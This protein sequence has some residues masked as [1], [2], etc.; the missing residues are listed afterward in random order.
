MKKI[1]FLLV[2]AG[3]L[4]GAY[5]ASLSPTEVEWAKFIPVLFIG[6]VGVVLIKI[7][8]KQHATSEETLTSNRAD[9]ENSLNRI[10]AGLEQLEAE[11]ETIAVDKLRDEIDK[12]LRED[13]TRFAD[14]RESLTHIY[15]LQAYADV[16]SSFAAGERY[17]NRV[18]S[19]SADGYVDEAKAY[20][21]RAFDQFRDAKSRLDELRQKHQGTS[22]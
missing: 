10:I 1:G 19:A 13:L 20:V 21:T 8:D 9:I 4:G 2:V 11:K 22:A 17:V 3:F 12:R 7:S 15:G 16:M 18:W 5:L 14:A 6:A